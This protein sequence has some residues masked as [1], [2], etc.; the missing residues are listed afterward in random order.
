MPGERVPAQLRAA[1]TAQAAECCEYCQSQA[2]FSPDP[3]SVE[4][5]IPRSRGGETILSNLALSCQGCN[6][7]KYNFVEA[8][9]PLTDELAPLY[10]PRR[11][12]WLTHFAW[13]EEYRVVVGLTPTGRATVAALRLNRPAL[14]NLRRVL[15]AVGEHPP[16]TPNVE[17][18]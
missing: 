16:A 18:A 1:V 4:H 8:R 11:D 12:P 9:D 10:H 2:R 3:L 17:Q 7:H 13:A 15:Y 5:I 6:N 14:I